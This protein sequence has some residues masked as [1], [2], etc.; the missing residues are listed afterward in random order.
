MTSLSTQMIDLMLLQLKISP[1]I[2]SLTYKI[3]L[4]QELEKIPQ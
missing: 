4:M 2:Y 3:V 1:A